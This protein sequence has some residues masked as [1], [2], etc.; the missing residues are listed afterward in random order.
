MPKA[1][2]QTIDPKVNKAPNYDE[3]GLLLAAVI[4][5]VTMHRINH[6]PDYL[7]G[8][9]K[10]WR[11]TSF[12]ESRDWFKKLA[13]EGQHPRAMIIAC[14]DSR[15]AVS[16]LF[17]QRTG[18]LFVHRNIANLVPPFTPDGQHHGTAAAIE[19]AVKY[20][21]VSHIVVM[22]HS[23]CGGVRGCIDMCSGN[24]PEFELKESFIGRWLDVLRPGYERIADIKDE[25]KR[26]TAL[27]K[28]GIHVSLENLMSYPFVHQAVEEESL[29]LHGVWADISD[30]DLEAYDGTNDQFVEI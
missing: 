6:L 2:E 30:M 18:E 12:P 8:R 24:A 15:V 16:G 25:S 22:G 3:C 7:L 23:H 20:L 21:K 19:F 11:Q 4:N 13:D 28:E 14:C 17:G 26:Q 9:Y 10:I 1:S 29:S 5:G 27:E